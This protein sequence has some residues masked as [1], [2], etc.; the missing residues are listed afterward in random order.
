MIVDRLVET[1]A[2]LLFGDF[3]CRRWRL[4]IEETLKLIHIRTPL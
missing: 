1:P 3:E 2:G 4:D